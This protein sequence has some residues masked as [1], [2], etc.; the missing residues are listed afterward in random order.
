MFLF[1]TSAFA[2]ITAPKGGDNSTDFDGGSEIVIGVP[3][4]D[5]EGANCYCAGGDISTWPGE[6][7]AKYGTAAC[8][9]GCGGSRFEFHAHGQIVKKFQ[10]W[11]SS[12]VVYGICIIL[13]DDSNACYGTTS[14]AERC[15]YTFDVANF[16]KI[17]TMALHGN[18]KGQSLGRFEFTTLDI[19]GKTGKF[20]CGNAH[21]AYTASGVSGRVISGFFGQSGNFIDQMGVLTVEPECAVTGREIID[22]QCVDK[23]GDS[24]LAS[25]TD[26]GK[27]ESVEQICNA[28]DTE[29]SPTCSFQFSLT[30]S[31]TVTTTSTSIDELGG[32]VKIGAKF[33]ESFFDLEKMEET[34]EVSVTYSHTWSESKSMSVTTTES[35]GSTCTIPLEGGH[36][37]KA[38]GNMHAGDMTADMKITV[39]ETTQCGQHKDTEHD[40]TITI[41]NVAVLADITT[42]KFVDVD[43]A[44]IPTTTLEKRLAGGMYA[45]E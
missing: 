19:N 15:E 29:M 11:R 43:C 20:E 42:C 3:R 30:E 17:W 8:I 9:G 25:W 31:H 26:G 39:R 34:V 40:A 18:G 44:D 27:Y 13:S 38:V 33:S 28:C 5:L 23:Q 12:D 21:T 4:S 16:E 2:K 41:S 10:M 1:V 6:T 32:S 22:M 35:V 36:A 24:C 37:V 14:G 45:F 7:A